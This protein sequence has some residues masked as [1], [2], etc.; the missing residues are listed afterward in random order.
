MNATKKKITA[1]QS[2]KAVMQA[3]YALVSWS[4]LAN[5]RSPG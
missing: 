1:S 4:A 5:K 3:G 2:Q